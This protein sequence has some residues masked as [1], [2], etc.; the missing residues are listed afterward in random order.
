MGRFAPS[1]SYVPVKESKYLFDKMS[2]LG[3]GLI[4]G[5][6][7]LKCRTEGLVGEV[8]GVGRGLKNLQ[9][10]LSIG[11]IDGYTHDPGEGVEGADLVVLAT[12]VGAFGSMIERIAPNLKRGA[13]V[14]DVGSVKGA[15]VEL[16]ESRM[17]PGVFFV[18]GHPIAG[19]EDAGAAYSDPELFK[20]ARCVLTPSAKTDET[21]LEIVKHLWEKVGMRVT[22]MDPYRHDAVLAATSHLPQITAS[23][24][25]NAFE[26]LSSGLP[27]ALDYFG[28][29][30]RDTTRVASSPSEMWRDICLYNKDEILNAVRVLQIKL[31]EME[32]LIDRGDGEALFGTFKG[33][34]E[35]RDSLLSRAG[36]GG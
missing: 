19:K 35:F 29:G 20:G 8:V 23:T 24:L 36:E 32:S 10:A 17:P 18:G 4:G 16:L 26:E 28:S 3:V 2:I 27:E 7:G 6:L 33:A 15:V 11:A 30:F 13:V 34:K 25:V 9:D 22:V 31:K 21:A 1:K 12:P 14:T 5:S